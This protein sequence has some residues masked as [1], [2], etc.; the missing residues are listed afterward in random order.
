M[1]SR[2][3]GFAMVCLVLGG[4]AAGGLWWQRARAASAARGRILSIVDVE[5]ARDPL[6]RGGL[7]QAN[8]DLEQLAERD[9]DPSL[10]RARA[11]IALAL[12]LP[13]QAVQALDAAAYVGPAA[14]DDAWLRAQA[15]AL[16]HAIA[17]RIDDAARASRLAFEYYEATHTVVAALLAWQCA[18]RI[19]DRE[20]VQAVTTRLAAD[21]PDAF[22]TK[23]M[24]ALAE[25]DPESAEQ[26]SRVRS[27]Q[28]EGPYVLELETA[29]AAVDVLSD[30]E[31][32][33]LRGRAAM[34]KVLEQVPSSKPARLV[35]VLVCDRTGDIAGRNA[36]LQWLVDNF[37]RD[38][39]AE[40]WR[41]LLL[42]R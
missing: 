42:M 33:R 26:A 37:P 3:L 32:A 38:P 36:H 7:V 8:R 4:A 22:E 39:R 24:Q 17:G 6:D 19:D 30:D 31:T 13:E 15:L 27:L 34:Q 40:K 28:M 12:R 11:R 1:V 35:A 21:A 41:E 18:T 14:V 16:R 10:R 5:L 29:V 20:Q 9:R 25:F 2:G 23:V